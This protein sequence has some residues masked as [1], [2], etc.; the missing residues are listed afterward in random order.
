MGHSVGVSFGPG[1]GAGST[2]SMALFPRPGARASQPVRQGGLRPPAQQA[3]ALGA[4]ADPGLC[5]PDARRH[6]SPVA[7][8]LRAGVLEDRIDDVA[9]SALD[10][11]PD[12]DDLARELGKLLQA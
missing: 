3:L 4:I 11:G 5:V 7:F 12:V 10:A 6:R 1:R 9:D 2:A 8:D